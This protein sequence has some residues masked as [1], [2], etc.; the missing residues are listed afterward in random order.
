MIHSFVMAE[1]SDVANSGEQVGQHRHSVPRLPNGAPRRRARFCSDT[2][3]SSV[4]RLVSPLTCY[5]RRTIAGLRSIFGKFTGTRDYTRSMNASSTNSTVR[6]LSQTS[7]RVSDHLRCLLRGKD[8]LYSRM[9]STRP[10]IN[11]SSKTSLTIRQVLAR[12]ILRAKPLR[13]ITRS[14]L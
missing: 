3:V 6:T 11:T 4:G 5:S 10:V 7:S 13:E 9:I 8:V 2:G 12:V 1:K 14:A